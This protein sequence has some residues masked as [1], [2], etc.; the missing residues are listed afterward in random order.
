[1]TMSILQT[2]L[3]KKLRNA[4]INQ[5]VADL[6]SAKQS[7]RQ[8]KEKAGKKQRLW[9]CDGIPPSVWSDHYERGIAPASHQGIEVNCA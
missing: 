2:N 6:V 5:A 8:G 3:S 7:L 4:A 1:M 9:G